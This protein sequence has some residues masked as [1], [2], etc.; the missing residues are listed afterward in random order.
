M[1]YRNAWHRDGDERVVCIAC[2][3]EVDRDD[4]REYDKHG[5]RWD[6]GEKS[7]EY[8]CKP[9]D[10][11]RSHA[12]RRGLEERLVEAGAGETD[13]ETFLGR[14]TALVSDEERAERRG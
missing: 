13:R 6:R 4:A 14:Y 1:S 3:D 2:G 9:C 8:L 10:G 11:D 12:P 5:D 7:F